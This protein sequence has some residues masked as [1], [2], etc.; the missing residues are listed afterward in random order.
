M[1][2]KKHVYE[3]L[4]S[5]ENHVSQGK[6]VLTNTRISAFLRALRYSTERTLSSSKVD[7]S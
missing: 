7:R 6:N 3:E 1:P 2:T 4:P 5:S